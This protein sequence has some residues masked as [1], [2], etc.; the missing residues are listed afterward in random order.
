MC[1]SIGLIAFREKQIHASN[2]TVLL[3]F[4]F[5]VIV[6]PLEVSTSYSWRVTCSLSIGKKAVVTY[7]FIQPIK[8][9]KTFIILQLSSNYSNIRVWVHRRVIHLSMMLR[10]AS[11]ISWFYVL[12]FLQQLRHWCFC[13]FKVRRFLWQGD[14]NET[15]EMTGREHNI[16]TL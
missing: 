1:T 9:P 2:K 16:N 12:H 8:R 13:F 3:V 4:L 5:F 6:R 15:N 14:K 7:D 10:N 11:C